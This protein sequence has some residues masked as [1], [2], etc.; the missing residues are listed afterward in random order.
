MLRTMLFA[1]CLEHSEHGTCELLNGHIYVHS[2]PDL[3]L[4]VLRL[5]DLIPGL[6]LYLG[7]QR[8]DWLFFTAD[9]CSVRGVGPN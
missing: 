4:A 1:L 8:V 7:G 9:N 5:C 3:C 2:I 6:S